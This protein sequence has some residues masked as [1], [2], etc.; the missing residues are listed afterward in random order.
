MGP[1]GGRVQSAEAQCGWGSLGGRRGGRPL[2][3]PS[4]SVQKNV[5]LCL[6]LIF[7]AC[8][9]GLTWQ[10][11]PYANSTLFMKEFC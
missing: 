1:A 3:G 10:L 2:L 5:C 11:R 8:F 9:S 7:I 6:E 4:D